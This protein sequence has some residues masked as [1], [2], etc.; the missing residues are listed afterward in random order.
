MPTQPDFNLEAAHRYFSADCFNRTWEFIEK[1]SRT[2]EEEEEMLRLCFAS[3][4]HW[5]QRPDC[6]ASNLSIGYWPISRVFALLGQADKARRYAQRC[7]EA[8]QSEG[9]EPALLGYAYEALARAEL[10]A[11]NRDKAQDYIEKAHQA[12]VREPDPEDRR[13]LLADLASLV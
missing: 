13:L 2:P 7:L 11:G 3:H 4:Y 8:S 9:V 5:T 10:I 6:T 1:T 12:A